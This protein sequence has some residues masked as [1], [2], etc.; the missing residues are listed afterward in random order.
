[1]S[2]QEAL[3]DPAICKL[4]VVERHGCNGNI[5]LGLVK[6]FD[7]QRG[8]MA[9]SVAHDSHNLII[10]GQDERSMEIA[11]LKVAE[12]GGGMAVVDGEQ[13]IASLALPVAGLMSPCPAEEVAIQHE[14]LEIAAHNLGCHLPAPFMTLSF[15]SLPVIP[16]LRLTDQGLVDVNLF[17]LVDIWTSSE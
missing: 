10:V 14:A 9:S 3:N 1:M 17:K 5:A 4:A 16:E 8:A 12:M 2:V 15:L 13:V 7:L 6:G 11:A